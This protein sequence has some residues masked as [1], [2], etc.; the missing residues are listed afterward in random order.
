LGILKYV[1]KTKDNAFL[2]SHQKEIR[3][4]LNR[5]EENLV[6]N[7]LVAG[8]DWRDTR[9][10]LGD[11]FLLTNSCFLFQVYLLLGENAKANSIKNKINKEFWNGRHYRDYLG[12][13]NFDTLGNALAILLGVAPADYYDS[14]FESAKSTDTQFGYKLNDVTLPSKS[15]AETMVMLRTNQFGVIW[16]FI[17][18]FMILAAIK[19]K[20]IALAKKQFE[21]WDKLKGFF[22]FYDPISGKGHGSSDQTWSAALYLRVEKLLNNL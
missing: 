11:K 3:K 2:Q 12:V 21:K 13:E 15:K 20:K 9:L 1:K 16:P 6:K 18:G 22:E 10:E 14:I 4:A 17:H 5:I 7:G 8:G 19:A